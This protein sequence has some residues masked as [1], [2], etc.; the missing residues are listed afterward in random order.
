MPQNIC[1]WYTNFMKN[2]FE[3]KSFL[4]AYDIILSKSE[5]YISILSNHLEALSSCSNILDLGCGTGVPTIKFLETKKQVIAIDISKNS[6]KILIDKASKLG[7]LGKLTCLKAD[8]TNLDMIESCNYD[9]VSSMITAHLLEDF[10]NHIQESYRLLKPEGYFV[11]TARDI[12]GDQD[13]LVDIVTK[14]LK[15]IGLFEKLMN[16]FKLV[17]NSLLLTANNRSRSLMTEKDAKTILSECGFINIQG[18][19]NKTQGVM[20]TLKAQKPLN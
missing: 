10:E 17:I 2:I 14:S 7:Y 6:L 20:Y 12:R 15:S 19:Q 5:H 13:L 9:G 16:E 1:R 18:M 11:I 3:K 4:S 8:I